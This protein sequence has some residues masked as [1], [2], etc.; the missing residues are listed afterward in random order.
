M[1]ATTTTPKLFLTDYAS[2]NNGTQFEFGHWVDLSDFS[3][4]DDF[5]E[6]IKNH[7]K[8]ADEKSPLPCGTPRE[9][10]MFTDFEGM[11]R[12]LYSE[13]MS[14]KE[15]E[16][17]FEFLSLG[18]YDKPRAAFII[19]QGEGIEY[20]LIKYSDVVMYEDT[21]NAKYDIF[22]QYYP[23]AEKQEQQCPYIEINYDRFIRENF[24]AFEYEGEHFLV[25]DNWNY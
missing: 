6:Y 13:S 8:E 21:E 10:T 18:E 22:E 16:N 7:F 1:V 9:E 15:M 25:D 2:Y 23:E 11:P 12:A 20:A 5:Q 24:T 3:N 19:E 17:L 4:A 14:T